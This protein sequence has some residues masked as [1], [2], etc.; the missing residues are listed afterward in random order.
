MKMYFSEL[1]RTTSHKTNKVTYWIKKCD[2]F[3]RISYE[4]YSL[5]FARADG[6]TCLSTQTNKNFTRQFLTVSYEVNK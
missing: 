5:R 4:E 3:T 1:M 6:V 2:V